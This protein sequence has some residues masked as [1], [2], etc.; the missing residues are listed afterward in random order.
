M[1]R[2]DVAWF[3]HPRRRYTYGLPYVLGTILGFD[4]KNIEY[5]S[6]AHYTRTMAHSCLS[7]CVRVYG[8]VFTCVGCRFRCRRHRRWLVSPNRHGAV[9]RQF[10]L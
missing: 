8:R 5:H 10:L 3:L 1:F 9:Y 2:Q 4:E 6:I 7:A